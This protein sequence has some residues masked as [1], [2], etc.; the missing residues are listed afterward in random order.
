MKA[1]GLVLALAVIVFQ[2]GCT[3][4]S[5]APKRTP[6]PVPVAVAT[7]QPAEFTTR[8]EALG[9]TRA[10]E[11]VEITALVTDRIAEIEF[12][13]GDRVETGDPLVRLAGGEELG[14]LE[15]A[16]VNLETQLRELRRIE[17]LESRNLVSKQSLDNQ[18]AAVDEARARLTAAEARMGE[19][20]ITAPFA[21]VLG[22]REVSA[23]AL[24]T[25]GTVITTLDD[26]QVMHLDF[27]VPEVYLA[28]LSE[29]LPIVAHSQAYPDERFE[30]E[31]I[32]IDS[33]V[34]PGTRAVTLR[35]AIGN[36][37]GRLKPGMLLTLSLVMDRSEALSVPEE[38]V[39]PSGQRQLVYRF[40]DEETFERTPVEI[41]RR[42]PGRVE[43]LSGLEA[44][45]VIV[46]E[47]MLLL[48]PGARMRVVERDGEPVSG[49]SGS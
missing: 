35:G 14:R 18:K 36:E 40:V 49:E 45:D 4:T 11:S 33:R 16:R 39:I 42:M 34:A 26:T 1:Q 41:G 28:S 32:Q 12:E 10:R 48:R 20:V 8:V 17:G 25:P 37:D 22:L 15:E 7:V 13:D 24:V 29:G 3:D 6:P 30:G 47:G 2:F 46:T 27:T 5:E 38:A 21:G 44:G 19:R 23:G 9:T 31:V 43:V